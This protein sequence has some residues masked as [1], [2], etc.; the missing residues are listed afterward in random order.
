MSSSFR[1]AGLKDTLLGTVQIP[2][3]TG[4]KHERLLD[5]V[6]WREGSVKLYSKA[7]TIEERRPM[8]RDCRGDVHD[9]RQY[10]LVST[11]F[12][13]EDPLTRSVLTFYGLKQTQPSYITL[14]VEGLLTTP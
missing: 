2:S 3:A 4:A 13:V 11:E 6:H 1:A 9:S 12:I 5:A 14:E 8:K 7:H 10:V